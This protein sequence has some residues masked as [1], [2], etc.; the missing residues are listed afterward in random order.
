MNP[1]RQ[2]FQNPVPNVGGG[3][4]TNFATGCQKPGPVERVRKPH[5]SLPLFGRLVAR[6][7]LLQR[8]NQCKPVDKEGFAGLEAAEAVHQ[9]NG[10]AAFDAEQFLEYGAVDDGGGEAAEF[11]DGVGKLLQ[12]FAF[13][14]HYSSYLHSIRYVTDMPILKFTTL[15]RL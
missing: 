13:A 14:G 8:G 10:G 5:V 7:H 1:R 6:G 3:F 2:L 9:P 12:P 15:N 11:V 4:D